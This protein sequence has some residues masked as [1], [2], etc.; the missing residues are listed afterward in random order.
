MHRERLDIPNAILR[1]VDHDEAPHGHLSNLFHQ[2]LVG[3][4]GIIL[5]LAVCDEPLESLRA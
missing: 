1:P 2:L 3:N 5:M 4:V